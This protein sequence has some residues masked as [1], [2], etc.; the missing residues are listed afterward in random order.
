MQRN[1]NVDIKMNENI[2]ATRSHTNNHV[3][4]HSYLLEHI[5]ESELNSILV[6][7]PLFY[8]VLL[9]VLGLKFKLAT[10]SF[11]PICPWGF[12]DIDRQEDSL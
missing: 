5:L 6:Y 7:G 2:A 10:I 12:G 3:L 1:T 8:T 4:S 11:L 9:L